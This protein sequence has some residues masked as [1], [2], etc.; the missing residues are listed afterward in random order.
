MKTISYVDIMIQSFSIVVKVLPPTRLSEDR[1][2]AYQCQQGPLPAKPTVKPP[3]SHQGL[4]A[5]SQPYAPPPSQAR[6]ALSCSHQA[7]LLP[8]RLSFFFFFMSVVLLTFGVYCSI[9]ASLVP[10]L[11]EHWFRMVQ[12][13]FSLHVKVGVGGG[14]RCLRSLDL[15]F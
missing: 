14:G 11:V 6:S 10:H 3:L 9:L 8:L 7:F 15:S 4:R 2:T 12:V 5:S 13:V 1:G